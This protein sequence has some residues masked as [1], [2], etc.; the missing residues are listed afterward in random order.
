[1]GEA[2]STYGREERC[3]QGCGVE[4]SEIKNHLKYSGIGGRIVLRWG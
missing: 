4:K 1:M 3:I 2:C